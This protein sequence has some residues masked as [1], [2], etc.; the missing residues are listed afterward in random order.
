MK[1]A[2][3]PFV[4]EIRLDERDGDIHA[5]SDDV[6]GLNICGRDRDE[7]L[8]DV[9]G[10]IKFLY[11]EV[12]GIDVDVELA[13]SAKAKFDKAAPSQRPSVERF[14]MRELVAA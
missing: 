12:A 11:K 2:Q 3:P 14:V 5:Y 4:A 13:D 8:E 9:V 1:H 7:V 10:A 6:P